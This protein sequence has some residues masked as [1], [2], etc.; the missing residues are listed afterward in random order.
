MNLSKHIYQLNAMKRESAELAEPAASNRI[1][2]LDIAIELVTKAQLDSAFQVTCKKKPL[3][4]INNGRF[5][6]MDGRE[7]R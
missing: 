5:T 1:A 6:H 7:S 2:A 4:G 3:P